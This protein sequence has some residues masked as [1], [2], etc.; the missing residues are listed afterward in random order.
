MERG[1]PLLGQIA[2]PGRADSR[3]VNDQPSTCH[4]HCSII[5]CIVSNSAAVMAP[6]ALRSL[7]LGAV[8]LWPGLAMAS[9]NST[10]S[11]ADQLRAQLAL[12]G[13]APDG[14][15]PWCVDGNFL[16]FVFALTILTI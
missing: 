1:A 10:Y 11:Q 5:N 7:L 14:C 13:D 2:Y 6:S 9:Q 3:S 16:S 8:A 4:Q 12:M 15:P